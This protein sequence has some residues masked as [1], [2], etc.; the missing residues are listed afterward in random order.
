MGQPNSNSSNYYNDIEEADDDDVGIEDEDDEY[1]EI[2]EAPPVSSSNSL[3]VVPMKNL[4]PD[5]PNLSGGFMSSRLS[6]IYS[7]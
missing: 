7:N 6:K 2:T 4:L 3:P 5:P 1:N